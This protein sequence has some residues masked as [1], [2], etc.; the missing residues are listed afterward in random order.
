MQKSNKLNGK[1]SYQCRNLYCH[2]SCNI[3]CFRITD[4]TACNISIP[5]V[6]LAVCMW[7]SY[8]AVLHKNSE[9]RD[10][11]NYRCHLRSVF[12]SYRLY[13]DWA[14]GGHW[15]EFLLILC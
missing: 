5:S 14:V 6:Y 13:M 1:R 10:A 2:D 3:F 15:A 9:I 4:C 12:L 8:D 11:D 7:H